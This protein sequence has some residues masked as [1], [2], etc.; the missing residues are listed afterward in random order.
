[1]KNKKSVIT[2]MSFVSLI[3]VNLSAKADCSVWVNSSIRTQNFPEFDDQAIKDTILKALDKKGY[4]LVQ[5]SESHLVSYELQALADRKN[6]SVSM[7]VNYT[8]SDGSMRMN[9]SS[10]QTARRPKKQLKAVRQVV[11]ESIS[12]IPRCR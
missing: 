4:T 5:K 2:L 3:S 9:F 10:Y 1:M 7:K 11:E 12:M 6:G 8:N